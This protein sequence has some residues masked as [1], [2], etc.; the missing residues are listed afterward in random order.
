MTLDRYGEVTKAVLPCEHIWFPASGI[1]FCELKTNVSFLKE[2]RD[3]LCS[4]TEREK[5][6]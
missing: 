4:G 1:V 3:M 2:V 5:L 6:L